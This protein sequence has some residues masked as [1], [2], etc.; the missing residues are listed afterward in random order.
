MSNQSAVIQFIEQER[1][2][3]TNEQEIQHQLLDAGWHMDIIQSAMG[4]KVTASP[5][6]IPDTKSLL[7]TRQTQVWGVA[8]VIVI[9]VLL[10]LFI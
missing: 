1:A 9:L 7:T 6:K 8:A 2:K 4:T 5:S 3:G 10:A